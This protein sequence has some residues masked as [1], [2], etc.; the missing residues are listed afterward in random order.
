[1]AQS[2]TCLQCYG[3][4]EFPLE[5]FESTFNNHRSLFKENDRVGF[6]NIGLFKFQTQHPLICHFFV[7]AWDCSVRRETSSLL[8]VKTSE[9][10]ICFWW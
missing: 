5:E 9:V 10:C 8:I 6:L 7:V 3:L 1:M 4:S 2:N